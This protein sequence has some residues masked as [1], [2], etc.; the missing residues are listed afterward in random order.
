MVYENFVHLPHPVYQK[1]YHEIMKTFCDVAKSV[2]FSSI[3]KPL[4]KRK[5]NQSK[6]IKIE[7]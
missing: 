7:E 4:K 6:K 1:S 5:N 2:C 3:K